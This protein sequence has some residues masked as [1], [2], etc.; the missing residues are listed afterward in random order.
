[1]DLEKVT[2]YHIFQW[3][4]QSCEH[5]NEVKENEIDSTVICENCGK[6]FEAIFEDE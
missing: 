3:H 6:E 4:C 1:M 2:V 5:E